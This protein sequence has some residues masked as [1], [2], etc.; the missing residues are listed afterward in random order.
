MTCCDIYTE[1]TTC[2]WKVIK[3]IW[4]K[5]LRKNGGF[6]ALPVEK[7]PDHLDNGSHS[8]VI[9]WIISYLHEQEAKKS[10]PI[11]WKYVT[12]STI[13]CFYLTC[14]LYAFATFQALQRSLQTLYKKKH[15]ANLFKVC[16][17]SN[18]GLNILAYTKL[19]SLYLSPLLAAKWFKN[20]LN[21]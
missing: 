1:F 11:S 2:M 12:N 14:Y 18:T 16:T 19:S 8:L 5:A 6:L 9:A 4:A 3:I 10:Y 21:V 13:L 15:F 20:K 17:L 7:V